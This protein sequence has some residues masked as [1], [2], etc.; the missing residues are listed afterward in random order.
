MTFYIGINIKQITTYFPEI[1][2][3]SPP[4]SSWF[5]IAVA[6][7]SATAIMIATRNVFFKSLKLVT[8]YR[9]NVYTKAKNQYGMRNENV[10][11]T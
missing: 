1:N 8:V 3:L 10:K 9:D 7:W 11:L 2:T 5:R 6:E 4:F